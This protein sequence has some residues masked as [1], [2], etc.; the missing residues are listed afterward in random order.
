MQSLVM[1]LH[2]NVIVIQFGS[3]AF[4]LI[5]ETFNMVIFYCTGKAKSKAA[6]AR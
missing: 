4:S 2:Y 5:N 6:T 1:I 3:L